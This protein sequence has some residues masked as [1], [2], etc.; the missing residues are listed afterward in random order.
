[1]A[2][3][4]L[5]IMFFVIW[6]LHKKLDATLCMVKALIHVTNINR[7]QLVEDLKEVNMSIDEDMFKKPLT[8]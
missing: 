3:F 4:M 6:M 1:M 7:E 5:L 8:K 2:E